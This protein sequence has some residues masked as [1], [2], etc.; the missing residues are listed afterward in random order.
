MKVADKTIKKVI[1]P[2]EKRLLDI[3]SNDKSYFIDIY[4]REYKWE[5]ENVKTLLQDIEVRFQLEQRTKSTP[6]DIGKDVISKFEPYFLNSFLTHKTE[7]GTYIVDGQQ[8]LTTFLLI[9]IKMF[10]IVKDIRESGEK[11]TYDPSYLSNLIFEMDP[12]GSP[13]RFKIYNS[14]REEAFNAIL[15]KNDEYEPKDETQSKILDNY[16]VLNIWYEK[17]FKNNKGYDVTKIN[18]YISYLL[19]KLVIIEVEITKSNDVPMI[20]EVVNDRGLGLKPYEILK[21]KLIG[22]LENSQKEEASRVWTEIQNNYFNLGISLDEFFKTFLRAK[23]ADSEADYKKFEDKYHYEIYNKKE[24]LDYFGQFKDQDILHKVVTEDIYYYSDLYLRL[25]TSNEYE[26]VVYNRLLDQN[27]QYL[28]ILSFINYN[29]NVND[30]DKINKISKK[31][32]QFHTTLRLLNAYD[33]NS[34]Q[35]L[36]YELN[37]SIRNKDISEINPIFDKIFIEAVENEEIIEKGKYERIEDLYEFDRIKHIS[38]NWLNFSKYILMRVDLVLS[39]WLN[40]KPSYVIEA[41]NDLESIFNKINRRRYGLQLEHILARNEENNKLFIDQ[42]GVFDEASFN[43]KRNLMGAVLLLKDKHNLSS[44][45]DIYKDKIDV[46]SKSDIIWNQILVGHLN[47]IDL[48]TIPETFHFEVQEPDENGLL[49]LEAIEKRQKELF[50]I[51]KYIWCDS[52]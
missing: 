4:Q 22:V 52:M 9:L 16:E 48:K 12:F 51:I 44:G 43:K 14:N 35:N 7:D 50:S 19:N 30:Q 24:I 29:G 33:S 21:G 25:N 13:S 23:F 38:N 5:K 18:Y 10:H 47:E 34:F 45:N 27:Q 28:I 49:P 3:F 46:Y 32:D 17:F 31:F 40:G 11:D 26:H 15:K 39:D 1:T 42:N 37:K 2:N 6:Q 41:G 20:F 36:I 8:R